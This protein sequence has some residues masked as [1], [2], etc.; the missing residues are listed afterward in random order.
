M[1]DILN[2][3]N[4]SGIQS[5]YMKRINYHGIKHTNKEF[6]RSDLWEFTFST[7]PAVV[8]YPGDDIIQERLTQVNP[9]IDTSVSGFT[10]THR[11]NFQ[12]MQQT[13]QLTS[14]TIQLSFID[15]EDQSITYFLDDWRNKIADRD[16]KFSFRKEDLV[17]QCEYFILNSQRVPVRKIIFYNCI[18]TDAGITEEGAA[19]DG[20]D[21]SD[22]S[23][24]MSF[25][26]YERI[27]MNL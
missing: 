18:I 2:I 17:A 16:T 26:H 19:E 3:K 22:V 9:G 7:P 5:E 15:R 4:V 12:L 10:K 14:G 25:E 24:T 1:A 23:L 27:F 21:R 13:G 11:Q 6:L 20:G 8:Y